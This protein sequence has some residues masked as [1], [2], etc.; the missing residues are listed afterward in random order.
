MYAFRA[1]GQRALSESEL[2]TR[3]LR[4]DPDQQ[5]VEE[6]LARVRELG[7]LNDAGVARQEAARRNVGAHRV[8][9]KL[10]QRGVNNELIE[11]AIGQRDPDTEQQELNALL[12][13]RWPTFAR[14]RDPRARAY[15]FLVRR[16]YGGEAIRR[17]LAALPSGGNNRAEMEDADGLE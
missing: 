6:V 13:R 7:Y 1:L 17:A 15:A 9:Q 11:A 2:K 12:E 16:G 4:R 10:R 14:A 5:R 3:M 8:R